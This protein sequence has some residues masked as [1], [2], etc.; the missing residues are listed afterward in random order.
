MSKELD[1]KT[2][3]IISEDLKFS[4]QKGQLSYADAYAIGGGSLC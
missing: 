3:Q 1:P 4:R 2:L